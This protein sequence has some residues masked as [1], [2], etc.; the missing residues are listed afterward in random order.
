MDNCEYPEFTGTQEKVQNSPLNHLSVCRLH[1]RWSQMMQSTNC[2][3]ES[4]FILL[5]FVW[6]WCFHSHQSAFNIAFCTWS[7]HGQ[8]Y[9]VPLIPYLR[10]SCK[11]NFFLATAHLSKHDLGVLLPTKT[12][13]TKDPILYLCCRWLK[14]ATQISLNYGFIGW[15]YW[16]V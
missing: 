8:S 4:L 10:V 5:L 13:L 9:F 2:I 1:L 6:S 16:K 3:D 11:T 15:C 12:S 7:Q 14:N